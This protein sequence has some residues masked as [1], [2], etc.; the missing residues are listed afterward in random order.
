[1][2]QDLKGFLFCPN[3]L[4]VS[5]NSQRIGSGYTKLKRGNRSSLGSVNL[6]TSLKEVVDVKNYGNGQSS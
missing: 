5:W 3:A 4:N 1:M 2:N 6:V